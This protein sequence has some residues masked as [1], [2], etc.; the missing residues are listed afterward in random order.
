MLNRAELLA[1]W[2]ARGIDPGRCFYTGWPTGG[3]FEVDYR[4]PPSRGGAD[5]MDNLVPCLPAVRQMKT[6]LTAV[7]FFTVLDTPEPELGVAV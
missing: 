3:V 1:H 6:Y 4:I 7:E 5:A 2:R